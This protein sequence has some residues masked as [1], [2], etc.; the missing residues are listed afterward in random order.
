MG[1]RLGIR[2]KGECAPLEA[3]RGALRPRWIVEANTCVQ[4]NF[5]QLFAYLR[6]KLSEKQRHR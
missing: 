2:R 6:R 5:F 4:K 3:L 1:C